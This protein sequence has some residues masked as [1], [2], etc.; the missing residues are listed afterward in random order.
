MCVFRS[1]T[2]YHICRFM[3][4]L[5]SRHRTLTSQGS[6]VLSFYSQRHFTPFP[7]PALLENSSLLIKGLLSWDPSGCC[8]CQGFI[9]LMEERRGRVKWRNIHKEPKDKDNSAGRME[10][11]RWEV[12]S[13][14]ESNGGGNGDNFNWTTIQNLDLLKKKKR[15]H[16]FKLLSGIPW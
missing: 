8:V 5:Q 12:G 15:V 9:L 10:W 2:F 14:R 6:P 3:W 7:S 13:V 1:L 4:P 11:G 16:S